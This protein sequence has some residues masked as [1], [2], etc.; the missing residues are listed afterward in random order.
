VA[1]DLNN[2]VPRS[3][4][5]EL[6]GYAWLPRLI[7]KTRAF[8]AGTHGEYSPYPCV[9]DKNF[10]GAFKLDGEALGEVIK[11]GAS[12]EEIAAWVEAHAKGDKAGFR[13]A[14]RQ[15]VSNPL[16]NLALKFVRG[17]VKRRL[18]ASQP[19]VAWERLDTFSKVLAVE[20]GHPLP[21]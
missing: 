1:L 4:F 3:P 8:Y 7:D 10:L 19:D 9:G 13:A 17:G 5:D 6:E 15:K 20:E 11:G 12:D 16:I 2:A 18:A 14:L 21:V